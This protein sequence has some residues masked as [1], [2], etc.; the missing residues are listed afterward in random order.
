MNRIKLFFQSGLAWLCEI[1]LE[2]DCDNIDRLD[3]M[4]LLDENKDMLRKELQTFT[5]DDLDE[6]EINSYIPINGGEFYVMP[7][8]RIELIK[9]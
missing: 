4:W 6:D 2:T 8:E 1:I 3:I 7:L 5:I 9:A